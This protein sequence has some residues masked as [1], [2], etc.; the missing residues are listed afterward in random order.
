MGL[1]S[2]LQGELAQALV[3]RDTILSYADDSD[4]RVTQVNRRIEAIR[5]RI[6]AERGS[7]G[8]GTATVTGTD[9]LGD[10]EALLTDMEFAQAAY[11]QALTNETVARAESRRQARYLA[12][13]VAPTL[14]DTAQFPRRWLLSGL[15]AVFLLLGW[16]VLV[17]FYYN[18]RDNN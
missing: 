12:A 3:E 6:E 1:M 5:K 8:L 11:T 15:T 4:H 16:S 7:L 9:V 18:V 10:Y 2:A 14:P 13:H 17:V